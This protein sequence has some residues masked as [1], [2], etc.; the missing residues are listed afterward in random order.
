MTPSKN[1]PN[2]TAARRPYLKSRNAGYLWS[3]VG[4]NLA[5]FLS[6]F[7][8]KGFSSSS[9]EHLWKGITTRDGIIATCIP[10]LTIVLSGLLGDQA[11]ARLVFWHWHNPLPGCRVFTDLIGNDARIDVLALRKKHGEFPRDPKEQNA[12]WYRLYKKHT[13]N[14]VVTEAHRNYLLTRDMTTL[15]AIFLALFSIG[16]S[17]DSVS[18]KTEYLYSTVLIAQYFIIATS[19]RNYGTRFVLNVL[20]EES[21]AK[22]SPPSRTRR[23]ETAPVSEATGT[24]E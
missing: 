12:L 18:W 10:L 5:V 14:V 2:A 8:T 13:G 19:A 9:I 22:E 21:H 7:I 11:K 15:S 24:H 20:A 16:I 6:V 1:S 3:F 4:V 17:F 23:R